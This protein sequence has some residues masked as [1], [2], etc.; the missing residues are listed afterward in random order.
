MRRPALISAAGGLLL[1]ALFAS[2]CGQNNSNSV[3]TGNPVTDGKILA[4]QHCGGCHQLVPADALT[5]DVWKH[6]VLPSMARYFSLVSYMDGY[7]KPDTAKGGLSLD[8]YTR[9]VTYYTTVAPDSLPKAKPPVPLLH[10][11]AGFSLK[12]PVPTGVDPFTTLA[13]VNPYN[14]KIYTSD[15]NNRLLK[16]WDSKLTARPVADLPTTAADALFTGDGKQ[17]IVSSIGVIMPSD[18]LNGRVQR[19]NLDSSAE[20]TPQA[21]A[22]NLPRPVQTITADLNKDGLMDYVVCGNGNKHGGLYWLKQNSSHG[23][24]TQLISDMPGAVQAVTGDFNG[25]GWPDIMALFG[26]TNEGLFLFTNNHSGGFT[27]RQL[28]KFPPVYGSTSFSLTDMDHDG[29][30]DVVYTCGYNFRDSRILKPYHGLYVFI[31]QGNWRLKQQYFYPING[32]TKA[33]AAD[34]NGDGI[35]DIAT[36]AF[37]ADMEG[38]PAEEFIYF[39]H[40]RELNFKPHAVPVSSYGRWMTLNVADLNSDNKPDI[41]L[42]NY[43]HGF[44]FQPNFQ[45]NWGTKYP[46]IILENHS[47]PRA[48][49]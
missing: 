38:N 40:T 42:G 32:C 24:D 49:Q 41:I 11:W 3:R 15:L 43:S 23:Y 20:V 34:F 29:K 46:F 48:G 25:D 45:P 1:A 33:I 16:E 17:A 10:D 31:N 27:Y 14:H 2:S 8:D 22:M 35:P 26:D 37:F 44:Q 19:V 9:I 12:L 30:P 21:V 47:K 18:F 5:K 7:F 36:I 4:Q 39:E 28:L 6:H 13:A